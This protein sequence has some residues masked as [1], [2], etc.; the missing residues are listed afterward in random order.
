MRLISLLLVTGSLLLNALQ[1]YATTPTL[2][3]DWRLATKTTVK[4]TPPSPGKAVKSS[5]IEGVEFATFKPDLRYLSSEWIDRLKLYFPDT[6]NAY[7]IPIDLT[8]QWSGTSS[9]FTM[10]YD[11]SVLT[12]KNKYGKHVNAAFL[13]RIGYADLLKRA[14]K[15]TETPVIELAQ[16]VSYSDSGKLTSKGKGLS[17]TKKIGILVVSKDTVS[18]TRLQSSVDVTITY[19]GTRITTTSACCGNDATANANASQEFLTATATIPGVNVTNSELQY[20]V[21]Q[22]GDSSAASPLPTDKVTVNY[23]GMYPSGAIFDSGSLVTLAL[24][25]PDGS[26]GVIEGWMEGLQLMK[27]GDKFRFFI[28]S[29]LAYG[30]AGNSSI[31]PNAA[32][33]FDVELVDIVK[34]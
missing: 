14:L 32:L 7:L 31:G 1:S 23:R 16:I 17:G 3:G 9:T 4:V 8:G 25:R 19:K 11:T 12:I 34:P 27:P 30:S 29:S 6:P 24:T 20:I 15:Y 5:A 21:L 22:H 18:G 26:D 2:V 33:V 13:S 10:T 28:P